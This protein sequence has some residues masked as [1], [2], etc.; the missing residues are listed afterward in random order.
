MPFDC[1]LSWGRNVGLEH[2][3]TPYFC[4]I[5][6]DHVFYPTGTNLEFMLDILE[7]NDLDLLGGCFYEITEGQKRVRRWDGMLQRNGPVLAMLP[8]PGDCDPWSPCDITH[9]FFLADTAAVREKVEGGWD[10]DL[11]VQEHID[12]FIRGMKGGLK[13]G[14]SNRVAVLHDHAPFKMY[15]EF[16]FN[17]VKFFNNMFLKKNGLSHFINFQGVVWINEGMWPG[18]ELQ[19]APEWLH[20]GQDEL[21]YVKTE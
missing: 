16:R 17:R 7:N 3:K 5:D 21:P 10:V 11:K 8:T 4:L 15:E 13:C 1:G 20:P 12:F 19:P 18:K 6:D 14:H 2:V 9:N